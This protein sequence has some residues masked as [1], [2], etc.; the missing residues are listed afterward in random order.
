[1]VLVEGPAVKRGRASALEPVPADRE[2]HVQPVPARMPLRRPRV[3]QR[4]AT[5]LAAQA[6]K[7]RA[8]VRPQLQ[9]IPTAVRVCQASPKRL[10]RF[11]AQ[12]RRSFARARRPASSCDHSGSGRPPRAAP[13]AYA[14][15]KQPPPSAACET[16]ENVQR[17]CMSTPPSPH[18]ASRRPRAG[19]S[20]FAP[21]IEGLAA[22]GSRRF[23]CLPGPGVSAP[24]LA[25]P[26]S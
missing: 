2:V 20:S 23:A 18:H 1:M 25:Q 3:R 14:G 9:R 6:T 8:N 26:R 13:A 10:S 17:A 5:K 7:E 4:P 11:A 22:H 16:S 12:Y 19:S 15:T 24:T 21:S